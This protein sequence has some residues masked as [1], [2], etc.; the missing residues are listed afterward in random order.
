[1]QASVRKIGNSSGVVL[2]K[3]V[4]DEL[5]MKAGDKVEMTVEAGK[6]VLVP[7]KRHVR[8]GWRE[9]SKALAGA[10]EDKLVWPEFGNLDDE[11]L[12]W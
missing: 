9:A 10:G 3:A 7:V 2:P 4:L 6:V 8:E 5:G 12:K 1:M 11:D